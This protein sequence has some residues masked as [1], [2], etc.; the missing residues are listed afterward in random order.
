[1]QPVE[2]K[3]AI[4]QLRT[5]SE[6]FFCRKIATYSQTCLSTRLLFLY[7]TCMR[8]ARR[9]LSTLAVPLKPQQKDSDENSEKVSTLASC[10]DRREAFDHR[11][12][13]RDRTS[14]WA[15][16]RRLAHYAPRSLSALPDV[17]L[18]QYGALHVRVPAA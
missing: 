8:Q 17:I 12:F 2:T 11:R 4:S 14:L 3:L 1:M 6:V 15:D 18:S 16:V 5:S 10:T 7:S 13:V 9:K